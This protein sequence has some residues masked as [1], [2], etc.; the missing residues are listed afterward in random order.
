M[1]SRGIGSIILNV[2]VLAS[3]GPRPLILDSFWTRYLLA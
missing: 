1:P 3:G 2:K